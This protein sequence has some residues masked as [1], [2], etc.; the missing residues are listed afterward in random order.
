MTSKIL[1]YFHLNF[2]NIS[3]FEC[4]EV[5]TCMKQQLLEGALLCTCLLAVISFFFTLMLHDALL[6]LFSKKNGWHHE[7]ITEQTE[8]PFVIFISDV[9]IWEEMNGAHS[10]LTQFNQKYMHT[11][12]G[13]LSHR[14]CICNF[15]YPWMGVVVTFLYFNF[16]WLKNLLFWGGTLQ[17]FI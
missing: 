13:A 10:Y 2:L 8:P 9:F 1:L 3:F 17:L 6:H 12:V 15:N 16:G 7:K 14:S 4:N 11:W 5:Q